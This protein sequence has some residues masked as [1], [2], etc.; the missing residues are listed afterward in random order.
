MGPLSNCHELFLM[1]IIAISATNIDLLLP[2]KYY[3]DMKNNLYFWCKILENDVY[4]NQA[5]KEYGE[6]WVLN[7][8]IVIRIRSSLGVLKSYLQMKP[9]LFIHLKYKDNIIG[10][11][12]INLQPLIPTDNIEEFLETCKN[13]SSTLNQRCYLHKKDVTENNETESNNSYLDLQLKLQYVGIK[14]DIAMSTLSTLFNDI[15]PLNSTKETKIDSKQLVSCS[16]VNG[17]INF[18]ISSTNIKKKI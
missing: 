14:T 15:V 13:N 7:E 10:R 11:S 16:I 6:L 1:N 2:T 5:K 18:I 4:F 17:N 12:K 8:K 3:T 9:F